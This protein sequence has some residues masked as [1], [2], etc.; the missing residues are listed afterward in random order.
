MMGV[1]QKS[2]ARMIN[3]RY[4]WKGHLWQGRFFSCPMDEVYTL[5]AARYIEL[6]P[7]KAGLVNTFEEYPY[8]S[9][10]FHLQLSVDSVMRDRY[11]NI[12]PSEWRQFIQ[13]GLQNS[14][15]MAHEEQ[16]IEENIKTGRPIGSDVFVEYVEKL[17]G[18]VLKRQKRGPK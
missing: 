14:E 11:F 10:R 16:V 12:S 6:N 2:Y 15:M 17:T 4:G 9:A 1:V 7:V 3:H 5:R 13:E 18:R 8:S